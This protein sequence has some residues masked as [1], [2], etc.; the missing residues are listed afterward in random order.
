[1]GQNKI[2][3]KI[4]NNEPRVGQTVEL[5]FYTDFFSKYL[6]KNL[7]NSVHIVNSSLFAQFK[8]GGI[9]FNLIFDEVKRYEIGPFEFKFNGAKYTTNSIIVNVRPSL[10]LEDGIWLRLTEIKGVK[11]LELEQRVTK[12]SNI[13]ILP[14]SYSGNKDNNNN[15]A[16]LNIK[17]TNGIQLSESLS[18]INTV[19]KV[20]YSLIKYKVEFNSE[21]SGSYVITKKDF[22]NFPENFQIDKIDLKNN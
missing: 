1:L 18:T 17:L 8:S 15:I 14:Y 22:T 6:Q 9:N 4:D 16:K 20:T 3:L 10:P 11:F 21:F 19:D 5:S 7:D 12:S 2:E 13:N